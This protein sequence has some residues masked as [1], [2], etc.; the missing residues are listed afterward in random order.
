M[1]LA[2][3]LEF[4]GLT[5]DTASRIQES[6]AGDSRIKDSRIEDS[7]IEDLPPPSQQYP[8]G[9]E[10]FRQGEPSERVYLVQRG[11]VKLVRGEPDG[12]QIIVALRRPGWFVGAAPVILE[13]PYTASAVTITRSSLSHFAA[14]Q[15]RDLLRD[16]PSLSWQVHR[17]HSSELYLQTIRLSEL[18]NCQARKRL[19]QLLCELA[20]SQERSGK[21]RSGAAREIKLQ[22][23]L[24]HWELAE[25]LAITPVY[26]SRLLRELENEGVI[27]RCKGW[28]VILN[29]DALRNEVSHS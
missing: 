20:A 6:T 22:L 1:P 2:D 15:F 18:A 23:P 16:H 29:V 25:V 19:K 8:P 3:T 5:V 10:L 28:I 21:D 9:T 4:P 27:R 11:L 17:M 7:G 24:K 14:D 26:L 12:Q 13:K